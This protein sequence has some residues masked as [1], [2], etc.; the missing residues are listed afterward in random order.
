MDSALNSSTP[1]I[2]KMLTY[3]AET[4]NEIKNLEI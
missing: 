1:N 2:E 4:T 3:F